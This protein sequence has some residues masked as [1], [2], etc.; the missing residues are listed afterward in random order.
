MERKGYCP[1]CERPCEVGRACGGETCRVHGM[2]G[3]PVAD[4]RAVH[5]DDGR[6]KDWLLGRM[7]DG[8][9][10]VRLIGSGGF[11]TV[12]RTLQAPVCLRES[13]LKLS[14]FSPGAHPAGPGADQMVVRE[15]EALRRLHHRNVVRL[16][17]TGELDR[18]A[19]LLMEFVPGRVLTAFVR[20]LREKGIAFPWRLAQHI[21]YQVLDGVGAAHVHGILHRDLKPDNLMLTNERCDLK[22]L[23]FGLAKLT[24]VTAH[25]S[26]VIGTPQYMA[27]EQF[28]EGGGLD[29][30]TD[31]YAIGVIAFELVFGLPPFPAGTTEAFR[32]KVL[33]QDYDPTSV[34]R[35]RRLEPIERQV[36]Q[37]AMRRLPARRYPS[38]AELR[39]ALDELF[40]HYE[41]IGRP[42]AWEVDELDPGVTICLPSL[43]S[44][45]AGPPAGAEGAGAGGEGGGAAPADQASPAA[46]DPVGPTADA[47]GRP[48]TMALPGGGPTQ[49][50]AP[51][52]PAPPVAL[53]PSAVTPVTVSLPAAA[54]HTQVLLPAALLP[55][56]PPP[57]PLQHT[58]A[59]PPTAP[60][61]LLRT[62]VLPTGAVAD[63]AG[64]PGAPT[65][66]VE[67]ATPTQALA[68]PSTA[69]LPAASS[70]SSAV[71]AA[72]QPIPWWRPG[73]R[74]RGLAV[75]GAVT[76]IAAC[77]AGFALAGDEVPPPSD[78]V[79]IPAGEYRIGCAPGGGDGC[80]PH[81]GPAHAVA[82]PALAIDRTP[83]SAADYAAC[84]AEGACPLPTV[85][86][87]GCNVNARG[88]AR[89]PR[90]PVNCVT[91]AEA[92]AYCAFRGR[93]LPTEAEWEAAAGGPAHTRHPWGGEA[94]DCGRTAMRCDVEGA[95]TVPVARR[96]RD[97]SPFGAA[98]MGGNVREWTA[99]RYVAYPG[100][101]TIV[102]LGDFVVRG[103]SYRHDA[104]EFLRVWNRDAEAAD[105]RWPDLGFRCALDLTGGRP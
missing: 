87:D 57:P 103:S 86:D 102:G 72:T 65:Q 1:M 37:T 36:F 101:A 7:V 81:D 94:P 63:T 89:R 13:A 6:L 42:G 9:L 66:P 60:P 2:H 16:Y 104:T 51:R 82:L 76:V 98:D 97:R 74:R 22:I 40:A 90:H 34:L 28:E 48:P 12:Y 96:A 78:M 45:P 92:E 64:F 95:G 25:L 39:G 33:E 56:A 88:E 46:V 38:A 85:P 41:R 105:A 15:M 10:I 47:A 59:L 20:E 100:G 30:T 83:V 21:L 54:P 11:G 67:A 93:R 91:Q 14:K 61:P 31:L 52:P 71:D 68:L 99:S 8:E 73:P 62:A 5:R 19:Y 24:D 80:L 18:R 49:G 23:D 17:R 75:T 43:V 44:P 53:R 77:F 69:S 55:A 26:K 29:A 70:P 32:C 3:I 4:F 35:G 84:V 27:P 50:A 79:L 58:A